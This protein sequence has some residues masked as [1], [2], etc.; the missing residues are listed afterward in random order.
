[1]AGFDVPFV[2][3]IIISYALCSNNKY[4]LYYQ[5]FDKVG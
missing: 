1:M 4:F 5:A 3:R 2:F